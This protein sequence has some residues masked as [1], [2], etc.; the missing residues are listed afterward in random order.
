MSP[1]PTYCTYQ[2]YNVPGGLEIFSPVESLQSHFILTMS[3]WSSGLPICFPSQGFKSPGGYLCETGIPLLAMSRYTPARLYSLSLSLQYIYIHILYTLCVYI[4]IHIYIWYSKGHQNTKV[5][6][7]L[8]VCDILFFCLGT[9]H[10][11]HFLRFFEGA[12][13]CPFI[14]F[15]REKNIFPHFQNQRYINS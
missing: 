11:R 14:C 1:W 12:P 6:L 3:H 15:A 10:M 8:K 9:E 2:K 4:Y 7:I 5:L 13:K